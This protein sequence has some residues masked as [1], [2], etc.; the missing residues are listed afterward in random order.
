LAVAESAAGVPDADAQRV[1]EEAAPDMTDDVQVPRR[2]L[3][4]SAVPGKSVRA[5]GKTVAAPPLKQSMAV[6]LAVSGLVVLSA[7]VLG[8]LVTLFL[9]SASVM[10]TD[11]GDNGDCASFVIQALIPALF[12]VAGVVLWLVGMKRRNRADA[13]VWAWWGAALSVSPLILILPSVLR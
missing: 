7:S 8:V 5:S 6:Q 9:L 2:A 3:A 13:P 11:G 10:C 4:N 1:V 12:A